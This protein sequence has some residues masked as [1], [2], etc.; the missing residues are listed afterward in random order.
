MCQYL[1]HRDERYFA[2]P[3]R[4][5]PE[6]WCVKPSAGA[7]SAYFP[8]GAGH[9]A[10]IAESVAWE[11]GMLLLAT[12]ASRWSARLVR[13]H[14]AVPRPRITLRSKHGMPMVLRR[15]GIAATTGLAS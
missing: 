9:R 10:C 14:R 1:V 7:R 5:E 4:F 2:S 3:G 8:F 13:G 6:R 12:L 11:E 15:R